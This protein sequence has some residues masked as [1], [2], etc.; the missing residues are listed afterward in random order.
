MDKKNVWDTYSAHQLKEL[1]VH[2]QEYM[3]FLDCGKTERECVEQIV[4][5]AEV[6]GY[7][8]LKSVIEKKKKIK[9]GDKIYSVL[10]NKTIVL[11]HIG[12]NPL[13]SGMNILGA[14]IDSPRMDV[15]Q[16]PLYEDNGIAYLDT[17]YY[18]GV[19]KYQWVTIPLALHGVAVKKD[20]TTIEFNLGEED[21]DPVFFVSDLLIHLA[22]EQMEK[23]ANKVIEGEALDI[24]VGNRPL[25]VAK[26]KDPDKNLKDPV[27]MAILKLLKD[28]YDMDE[29]DFLSAEL[30]VVPAGRAREA[31][32][33]R[34]MILA[35]GQD[36]RVCAFSSLKAMLEL[37]GTPKRTA[38]CILVDKEEIG[39]VGAT[40][41]RSRFFE[42]CVGEILA[43]GEGNYND[44]MLKR[45]LANSCMLSSDVS[46]AFDPSYAS[47]FEKKNAAFLGNGIVFNKFTGSRGKSGSNDANAEYMAYLRDI[48][49]KE[50]VTFQTAEL[51][52]VDLGG[53][54][55]IAYI[56]A[57]YG[58]NV[59][60]S[61]VAVLNMHAPWEATSKAD[62]YE[63]KR[64]Y[65]AFL[66][67]E[68]L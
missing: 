30:E 32:F 27:K 25:K 65:A 19:K 50:K 1:E 33:D 58:M 37:S 7:V 31:G 55:T 29:E 38:C 59:I 45:C 62:V 10:M 21:D 53:G 52:K 26:S 67:Y 36:D 5:Q 11:F 23:K 61:G 14:H 41:M 49:A 12:K 54:G 20:G 15:K 16:D 66:K 8:P 4:N 18:G 39:S 28:D 35:Y 63:A 17:H 13:E 44:L 46:A 42:N 6:A 68:G 56:L 34:S 64:G 57:L 47:S 24:I 60:D 9:P 2:A 51:G 43:L 22:Q 3:A 40:G 48:F